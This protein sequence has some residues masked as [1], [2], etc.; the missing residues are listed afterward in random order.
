VP[1]RVILTKCDKLSRQQISQHIQV[2][3]K[4]LDLEED[5]NLIAF[6]ALNRTGLGEL[7]DLV[8]AV[9]GETAARVD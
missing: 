8:A 2:M 3:T 5:V 4:L 7:R 9:V 6:S 1:Y